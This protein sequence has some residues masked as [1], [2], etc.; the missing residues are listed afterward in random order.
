[1]RILLIFILLISSCTFS[2]RDFSIFD[3]QYLNEVEGLKRVVIQDTL[4]VYERKD[5]NEDLVIFMIDKSQAREVTETYLNAFSVL[6]FDVLVVNYWDRVYT[7]DRAVRLFNTAINNY[8]S[9]EYA[10]S[11]IVIYG[12]GSTAHLALQM[13]NLLKPRAI[14]IENLNEDFLKESVVAAKELHTD[15]L[16]IQ[17]DRSKVGK[18]QD[19]VELYMNLDSGPRRLLVLP[20]I[21]DTDVHYDQL[22]MMTLEA[23]LPTKSG[24]KS[25]GRYSEF[26]W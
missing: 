8:L 18:L 23:T 3:L 4:V 22:Y 24:V 19:A 9:H 17:G 21:T 25:D 10:M 15:V 2:K 13:G 11:R 1:M 7:D 5:A 26:V 6:G 16:I 20:N 12:K 14:V